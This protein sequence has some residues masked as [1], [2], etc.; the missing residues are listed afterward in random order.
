MIYGSYYWSSGFA[1]FDIYGLK[2]WKWNRLQTIIA[3]H[4]N[5]RLHYEFTRC[6]NIWRV[7]MYYVLTTEP[8]FSALV[9]TQLTKSFAT[10]LR[11]FVCPKTSRW[12]ERPPRFRIGYERGLRNVQSYSV[13]FTIAS[14]LSSVM[15]PCWT[16]IVT[17]LTLY[18]G[19]YAVIMSIQN[20]MNLLQYINSNHAETTYRKTRHALSSI[21]LSPS[22]VAICVA[23]S[24]NS[25]M[26]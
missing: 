20:V 22:V 16:S 17:P 15:S 7:Y 12:I 11:C 26:L 5:C 19:P 21:L 2:K 4:F 14:V 9:M 3:S 6:W 13:R 1:L 24:D 25:W 23:H 8:F 18:T 10:E